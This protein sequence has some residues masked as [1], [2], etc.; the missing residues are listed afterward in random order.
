MKPWADNPKIAGFII[1]NPRELRDSR[2]HEDPCTGFYL[3]WSLERYLFDHEVFQ[4][5]RG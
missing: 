4:G 3:W 1:R 5:F 2:G